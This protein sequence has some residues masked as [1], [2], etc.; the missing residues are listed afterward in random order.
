MPRLLQPRLLGAHLLALVLVSTAG[1][2][3]YWQYGSWQERRAA[4]A[5]DLSDL[6]P[7]P[8]DD[9]IGPDDPFPA[10]KVGQPV[11]VGGIWVPTGTVYVSGR[12]HDGQDGY[13]VVTPLA[14]GDSD[15]PALPIVR[16]WVADPDTAPAPPTGPAEL[17]AWLQ[18]TQGTNE[19]DTD[20]S[21]DILPQV[22][23]ADLIQ[24]VDQ[25]LYGAYAVAQE[26]LDGLE[27]ATLEQLPD[28]GTF[29]ALKNLL[30]AIEWWLFGAFAAFIWWR[31]VRDVTQAPAEEDADEDVE[32]DPVPSRS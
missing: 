15:A 2:L 23:T 30:Y 13:W 9:V 31:W 5:A 22:R 19:V 20:R 3:G 24:H 7:E 17:V 25:D 1:L 21:D 26:P 11:E 12:E 6:E 10:D 28:A 29:T 32:S 14:V 8:L 4:E 16:G 27:P 18:P